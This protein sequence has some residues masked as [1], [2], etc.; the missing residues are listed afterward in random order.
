MYMSRLKVWHVI[1][2]INFS[3]CRYFVHVLLPSYVIQQIPQLFHMWSDPKFDN[4]MYKKEFVK[5]WTSSH[6]QQCGW[7]L[8]CPLTPFMFL[9]GPSKRNSIQDLWKSQLKET[10]KKKQ[11][12]RK[13]KMML[14][15]QAFQGV[16]QGHLTWSHLQPTWKLIPQEL[17][18]F[19]IH[20]SILFKEL[21]LLILSQ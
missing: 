13:N 9:K 16:G 8:D 14:K 5:D 4:I 15:L 6:L 18:P 12:K 10:N 7:Y 21:N 20:Q 2:H 19:R 17:L 3:T 1:S 11:R